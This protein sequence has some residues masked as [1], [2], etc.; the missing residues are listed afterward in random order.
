MNWISVKERLPQGYESPV[1][2]YYKNSLGNGRRVKAFYAP[3]KTIESDPE[4]DSYDEYDE[5]TETYYL[6]EGWY[7]CIDNWEDF[8]SVYIYQG[9]IT[10]WMPLP[11]PPEDV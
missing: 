8:S 4:G 11:E 5:D 1:L 3:E 7:E 6:R 2:A 9:N 10:H